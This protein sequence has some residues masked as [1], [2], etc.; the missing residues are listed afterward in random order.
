MEIAIVSVLPW[1]VVVGGSIGGYA[2]LRKRVKD[3]EKNGEGTLSKDKHEDLCEIAR[4][5]MKG[6]VTGTMTNFDSDVF[7]PAMKELMKELKKKN[8]T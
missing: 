4:L 7:K 8:G 1:V 3:L 2:V 5:E 6:H